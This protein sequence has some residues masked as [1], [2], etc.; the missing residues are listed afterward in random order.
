MEQNYIAVEAIFGKEV[1]QVVCEAVLM[2]SRDTP[3]KYIHNYQNKKYTINKY[4]ISFVT[5]EI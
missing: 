2:F 1:H 3:I 4:T 5:N